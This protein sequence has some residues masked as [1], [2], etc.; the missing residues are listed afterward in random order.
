MGT[1]LNCFLE[2]NNI[3]TGGASGIAIIMESILGIPIWLGN[4]IVNIPLF[5]MG[6]KTFGIKFI[7]KSLSATFLLSVF[8][9]ITRIF[10][11]F[12]GD[13]VL[14]CVF[15]GILSGIGL[16]LILKAMTTTGGSELVAVIINKYFP[17]IPVSRL[18]A[19]T[20]GI[21]ILAGAFFFGI[22]MALYAVL[23]V[24]ISSKMI[25]IV[26]EG[27]ETAKGVFIISDN[28]EKILNKITAVL[29]RGATCFKAEGGYSGKSKKVIFCV[30]SVS[31]L[32]KLKEIVKKEDSSAF[33]TIADM[34]EVIGEG[35]SRQNKSRIS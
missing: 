9:Y 4:L 17:Y 34:R 13:F 19:L 10:P 11:T 30:V 26:I 24:I 20:D 6:F 16:G 25:D 2:P 1:A 18:I 22:N 28:S 8:L 21:V 5:L 32:P 33:L 15:G 12:K 23:S 29:E 3:V 7:R 14:S 27:G 35:F 31:Q